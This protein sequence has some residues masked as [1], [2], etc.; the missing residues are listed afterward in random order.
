M[1]SGMCFQF[2]KKKK[3]YPKLSTWD[4][5]DHLKSLHGH[6]NKCPPTF[7]DV[8]LMCYSTSVSLSTS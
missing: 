5:F 3:S 6:T 2:E 4:H 8:P 1:Q 7:F